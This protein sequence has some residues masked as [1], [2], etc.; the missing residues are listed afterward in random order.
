MIRQFN[1]VMLFGRTY[2]NHL[3]HIKFIPNKF[4]RY[5]FILKMVIEDLRR[6]EW[7]E[8]YGLNLVETMQ[9]EFSDY[10]FMVDEL[11]KYIKANTQPTQPPPER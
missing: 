1:E 11:M 2:R 9:L 4:S 6:K 10:L 8:L 3:D 7:R 5:N